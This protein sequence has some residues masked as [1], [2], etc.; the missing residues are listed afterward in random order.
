MGERD[1]IRALADALAWLEQDE[2]AEARKIYESALY[3]LI[4]V[5]KA[6]KRI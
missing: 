1:A 5:L 4:R 6:N 2:T 3:N